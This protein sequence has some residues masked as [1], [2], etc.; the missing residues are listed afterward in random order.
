MTTQATRSRAAPY[1]EGPSD[2]WILR[3]SNLAIDT[4]G[5]KPWKCWEWPQ[6]TYGRCSMVF[7][8]FS[9]CQIHP[10]QCSSNYFH[11]FSSNRDDVDQGKVKIFNLGVLPELCLWISWTGD[12]WCSHPFHGAVSAWWHSSAFCTYIYLK[13]TGL[14]RDQKCLVSN[15]LTPFEAND[16]CLVYFCLYC[17]LLLLRMS[18]LGGFNINPK[19]QNA[20][21]FNL[22]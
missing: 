19:A 2:D 7:L 6:K 5:L 14:R 21:F 16:W 3:H 15:M 12:I 22:L 17:F 10:I 20:V 18:L 8:W 9:Y 1:W 13:L 4:S 11:L